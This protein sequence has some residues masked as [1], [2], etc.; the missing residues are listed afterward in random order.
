[1]LEL[2][3]SFG[4]TTLSTNRCSVQVAC[5]LPQKHPEES[6]KFFGFWFGS[7]AAA[8]RDYKT[9][10]CKRV[11]IVQSVLLSRLYL[12]LISLVVQTGHDF[13]RW[14]L[15]QTNRTCGLAYWS[16]RLFKIRIGVVHRT[17]AK[18]YVADALSR[19]PSTSKD[20]TSLEYD[21]PILAAEETKENNSCICLS[22][23]PCKNTIFCEAKLE[24]W[25]QSPPNGTE[26]ATKQLSIRYCPTATSFIRH[27]NS[28]FHTDNHGMQIQILPVDNKNRIVVRASLR[29]WT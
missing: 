14:V 7:L 8:E 6:A 22:S 2:L 4:N 17:G 21:L 5:V 27:P 15:N 11:T 10:L 9:T 24:W 29:K 18:Y 26:V 19:L 13:L 3:N 16:I 28:G 1:M 25:V 20:H 12:E 23:T